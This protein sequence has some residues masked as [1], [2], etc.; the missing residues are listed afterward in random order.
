MKLRG[1]RDE[2]LYFRDERT[3]LAEVLNPIQ[4]E[5]PKL[6]IHNSPIRDTPCGRRIDLPHRWHRGRTFPH[7]PDHGDGSSAVHKEECEH[8]NFRCEHHCR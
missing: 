2:R 8:R 1:F 6:S 7:D 4:H 3:N 5:T